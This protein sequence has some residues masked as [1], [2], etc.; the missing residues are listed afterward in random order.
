MALESVTLPTRLRNRSDAVRGL[1]GDME[2][3]FVGEIRRNVL[4]VSMSAAKPQEIPLTNGTTQHDHRMVNGVDHDDDNTEPERLDVELFDYLYMPM[5][6]V[7]RRQHNFSQ[8]LVLRGFD[9]PN[10]DP[11]DS[12]WQRAPIV[13]TYTSD[14]LAP[15]PSSFPSIFNFR[16]LDPQAS[17]ATKAALSASTD[18]AHRFRTLGDLVCRW[19]DVEDREDLRA[20]LLAKAEEYVDGYEDEDDSE[21]EG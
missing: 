1:M 21:D 4:K 6:Q 20:D 17:I 12:A 13:Q 14:S 10:E 11:I 2:S 18:I 7:T 5:N 16:Q 8:A 3:L 19:V 9:G 15:R